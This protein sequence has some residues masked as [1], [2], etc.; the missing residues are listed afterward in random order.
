MSGSQDFPEQGDLIWIDAEPHAGHEYVG[1]RPEN[2]NNRRPMLVISDG[3]YNRST[4][5]IVGFP[6]TSANIDPAFPRTAMIKIDDQSI[7]G[8]A[9]LT[10]LLGYD[11]IARHGEI[12]G[13][14]NRATKQK[15]LSA[16]R[17]I[18]GLLLD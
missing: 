18:F 12:V 9:I 17:N 10:G 5:M 3:L 16:V 13:T 6:I 8:H 4:K 14:V 11:Y 1:H 2:G 7:H 15:A